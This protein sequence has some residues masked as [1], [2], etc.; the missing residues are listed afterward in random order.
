[1]FLHMV[2]Y[3]YM[4]SEFKKKNKDIYRETNSENETGVRYVANHL[5][6]VHEMMLMEWK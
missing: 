6:L 4:R 1:M 2:F 3:A 5:K